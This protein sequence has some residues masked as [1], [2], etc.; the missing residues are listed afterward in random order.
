MNGGNVCRPPPAVFGT[1]ISPGNAESVRVRPRPSTQ[2][3]VQASYLTPHTHYGVAN[4]LTICTPPKA[5]P[6]CMSSLSSCWQ[7]LTMAACRIKAS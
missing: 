1:C 5:A 2:S 6:C 3:K 7:P 4:G